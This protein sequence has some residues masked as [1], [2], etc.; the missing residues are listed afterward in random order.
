[1]RCRN[2]LVPCC[3]LVLTLGLPGRL[4]A[5]DDPPRLPRGQSY[6]GIHFDLHASLDIANA[7]ESL[8]EAM[9]D[10]FLSRVKPDFVQVDCKGHPGI[11]SYPTQVADATH[12]QGFAK[13]PMR[14]WRD[15][16]ARHGV[17]LYVHYS[18]VW[19]SRAVALHPD[20]AARGP[21]GQPSKNNASVFSPYVD[22]ILIPQLRELRERYQI[23]G[24]WIDGECW[25]IQPDYRDGA[26]QAFRQATG[27]AG[28]PQRGNDPSYLALLDFTRASFRRYVGHYVDDLHRTAPGLQVTSNWAYSS[29]M[30]EPVDV[31][32]DYLSGDFDPL[33]SVRTGAFEGRCLAI[34]AQASGK[35]WDLMDWSFARDWSNPKRPAE[36]K[37]AL[38]L[39]QSAAQVLALGG[40][41]QA[42]FKQTRDLAMKPA[43]IPVMADLAAFCRA[44][45]A[46]C[47]GSRPVPQVGLLFST[48]GWKAEA[49][50][51]YQHDGPGLAA[52]RGVLDG[53][54]DARQSVE[55][56]MTHHLD[57]L[58]EYGL[59]VVP[60]WSVI[61]PEALDRIGR[62]VRDDGGRLLVVGP[63]AVQAVAPVPGLSTTPGTEGERRLVV[64]AQSV[65]LS[66]ALPGFPLPEGAEV[67]ARFEK[68]DD[69]TTPGA[70]A[71]LVLPCGQGRVGLI[72]PEV[73]QPYFEGKSQALAGLFQ[74]LATRLFPEP[75]A[76]IETPGA[77]LYLVTAR[78]GDT[79][80]VNLLN[81]AGPHADRNT[82][83]YDA[84]PPVGPVEV[85]I[86]LERPPARV[87]LEPGGRELRSTWNNGSLRVSVPRV[88]V[89]EIVQ[90][91][92]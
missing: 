2:A 72:L 33:D 6:F 57:R 32:L 79:L 21:D 55:I 1:M 43:D 15:V 69:G 82:P 90:V 3:L 56:L 91:A 34:Q 25:A 47:Q 81:V 13:D 92:P 29:R 78:R 16:T 7:G 20:W 42:Y 19:D 27:N 8:T 85:S 89:H 12:V 18:G 46:V 84:I 37:T 83:V 9:L 70:P 64:G 11:S 5:A 24:A 14:I 63:R 52:L 48:A 61:E 86:R 71:A 74:D 50:Q 28:T 59:L 4:A 22:R 31:P 77:P 88:E 65:V 67:V 36:P 51:V 35:P 23:D 41:Y 26:L 76:R 54:L 40:A 80:L 30:P 17:A 39:S 53:L 75:L 49:R 38:Q 45:Q 60:N 58:S 44:R 66:G 68:A 73:G 87:T 10:D 62:W